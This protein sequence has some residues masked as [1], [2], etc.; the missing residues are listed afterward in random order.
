MSSLLPLGRKSLISPSVP[1]PEEYSEGAN[2]NLSPKS[3]T[4]RYASPCHL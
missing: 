4:W 1:Q 2:E 3:E